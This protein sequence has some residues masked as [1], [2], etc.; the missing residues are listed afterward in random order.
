MILGKGLLEQHRRLRPAPAKSAQPRIGEADGRARKPDPE[1]GAGSIIGPYGAPNAVL[2]A[3]KPSVVD[4]GKGIRP[5]VKYP[6]GARRVSSLAPG[7]IRTPEL[8]RQGK[9]SAPL[10]RANYLQRWNPAAQGLGAFEPD[11]QL[12]GSSPRRRISVD[13]YPG[14]VV[15]E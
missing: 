1:R 14:I 7:P 4:L 9:G 10:M 13:P 11:P 15:L 3:G 5:K 6:T 8:G 12:R 2:L